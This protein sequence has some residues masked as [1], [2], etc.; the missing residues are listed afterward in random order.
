M[1]YKKIFYLLAVTFF[2]EMVWAAED[3]YYAVDDQG[4]NNSQF[5]IISPDLSVNHLGS[6]RKGADIEGLDVD[7]LDG[8]IYVSSGD[9]TDNPGYLYWV[10]PTNGFPVR[11]GAIKTDEHHFK[12]V[13]GLSFRP[14]DYTLWGWA[15]GEGLLTY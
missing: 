2:S 12:E 7:P 14:S 6:V 10:D 9:D 8:K 5:F 15:Q 3:L 4:L 1:L 13:D 11:I